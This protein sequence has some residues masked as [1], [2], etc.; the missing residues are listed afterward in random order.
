VPLR[1]L[2]LTTITLILN[3]VRC[4]HIPQETI[5]TLDLLIS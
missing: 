3:L 2:R 4:P 1:R 5:N